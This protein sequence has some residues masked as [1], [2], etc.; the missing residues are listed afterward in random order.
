MASLH[1]VIITGVLSVS[2]QMLAQEPGTAG[3]DTTVA[4]IR[5]DL[6]EVKSVGELP[7]ELETVSLKPCW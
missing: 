3:S 5:M 2:Y 4:K 1:K 7:G 6:E